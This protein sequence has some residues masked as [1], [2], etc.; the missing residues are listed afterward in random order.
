MCTELAFDDVED[1][2]EAALAVDSEPTRAH[3]KYR[4]DIFKVR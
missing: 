3:N 2:M 4:K 1:D